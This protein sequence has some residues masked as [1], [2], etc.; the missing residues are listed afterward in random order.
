MFTTSF[1]A[2][3]YI[4][5]PGEILREL[6]IAPKTLIQIRIEMEYPRMVL[7]PVYKNEASKKDYDALRSGPQRNKRHPAND[8]QYSRA[9]DENFQLALPE[10]L[11]Y[12]LEWTENTVLTL[13]VHQKSIY[14]YGRQDQKNQRAL[15]HNRTNR[16]I[17]I[18]DYLGSKKNV[19]S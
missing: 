5:L 16:T 18:R 13:T 14:L 7:T 4:R 17:K 1:D 15:P 10:L 3:G 2:R 6:G 8:W 9:V 19:N 12:A 11:R